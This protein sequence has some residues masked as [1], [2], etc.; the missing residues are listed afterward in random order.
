MTHAGAGPVVVNPDSAGACSLTPQPLALVDPGGQILLANPILAQRLGVALEDLSPQWFQEVALASSPRRLDLGTGDEAHP[1]EVAVTPLF[2]ESREAYLISVAASRRGCAAPGLLEEVAGEAVWLCDEFGRL[3]FAS[4][5]L[6]ELLGRESVVEQGLNLADCLVEDS[7]ERLREACRELAQSRRPKSLALDF[8]AAD[9]RVVSTET[10]LVPYACLGGDRPW[11]YGRSRS[12]TPPRSME[13]QLQ[14]MQRKLQHAQKLE[15]VGALAAGVA[16]DFNN[17]LTG[18]VGY[19]QLALMQLEPDTKLHEMIARIPEQAQRASELTSSLLSFSRR[20]EV[21]QQP[22]AI[23]PLLK[24]TARMLRNVMPAMITMQVS[25]PEWVPVVRANPTQI[26]QILINLATNARDAMPHGGEL[27]LSLEVVSRESESVEEGLGTVP[28]VCLR[29]ED[30][31]GGIPAEMQARVF[32]PFFTTKSEREGTGLGLAT[33]KDLAEQHGGFVEVT[34]E[35][36]QGAVFR[37]Y[38]PVIGCSAE[39]TGTESNAILPT[40]EE[41]ILLVEDDEDVAAVAR[42]MLESLG[43]TVTVRIDAEQA[44]QEYR[45][46]GHRYDLVVTDLS[47]P[48]LPGG[49]VL[50][51][52]REMNPEV[53]VL[54]IS[55]YSSQDYLNELQLEGLGGF[56]PKPFDLAGLARAVRAALDRAGTVNDAHSQAVSPS[57]APSEGFPG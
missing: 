38:L 46:A 17:L 1:V 26:Q 21:E 19:A 14:Q 53:R 37:V 11:I 16:H 25:W 39:T 36:G 44:L 57:D 48:K 8:L 33:V 27:R 31:G 5:T 43:Y 56:V 50:D 42:A 32:E 49:L 51:A 22:T 6:E 23:L 2:W 18:I 3:E 13:E 9:E 29:V 54:A 10:V 35:L 52:L 12:M 4:T 40:G 45:Y 55:G 24:E 47:L 34:S 15:A 41:T 28:H 7:A 20:S 30:T